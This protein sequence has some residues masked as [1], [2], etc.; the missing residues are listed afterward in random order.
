MSM[1]MKIV[2]EDFI[3]TPFNDQQSKDVSKE[4]TSVLSF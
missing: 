1:S 3:L 2:Q 4:G